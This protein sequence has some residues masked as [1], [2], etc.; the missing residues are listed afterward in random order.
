MRIPSIYATGLH[1]LPYQY[2]SA[3][4]P[5]LGSA[6]PSLL[7]NAKASFK[8]KQNLH[9]TTNKTALHLQM[10]PLPHPRL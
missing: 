10:L 6:K 8:N 1:Y 3:Q 2:L 5:P 9:S 7:D 4:L